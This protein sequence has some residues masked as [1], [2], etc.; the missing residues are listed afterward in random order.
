M[1][2]LELFES[3][4]NEEYF[5]EISDIEYQDRLYQDIDDVFQ[6]SLSIDISDSEFEIISEMI[7][8]LYNCMSEMSN[9]EFGDDGHPLN[10]LVFGEDGEFEI[11]I[12]KLPDE[13]FCVNYE[14][15]SKYYC[16]DQLDGLKECI[17]HIE[18]EYF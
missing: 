12:T 17:K 16:C 5:K 2:Y 11:F 15:R 14:P 3:F 1:K 18:K 7:R 6:K 9:K 8:P 4:S 10:S 13:W